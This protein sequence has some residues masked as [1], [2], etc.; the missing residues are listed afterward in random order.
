MSA[1]K[2]RAS[3]ADRVDE[4]VEELNRNA[5]LYHLEDRP[6]IS[7]AEYDRMYR[8]LIELES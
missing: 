4:L 2:N 7:D 1:S 5:R 3:V 6:V 8:E